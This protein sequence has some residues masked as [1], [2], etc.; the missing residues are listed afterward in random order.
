MKILDIYINGF[1]KFHGRNLSFEDGLN[2]VYVK[3][4]SGKSTI[5]TFIRGMLFGIEKQRGRASRNDL[6]SKFE[7]WENSGTYEGQLRLE[8]KDH[9]YRIERTF[10]KNKKEFKVVDETAGDR[11]DE[12]I[13]RRPLKRFKRDR[14]Q[15]HGQ[16]RSVKKRNR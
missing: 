2:I 8:H 15:Q 11:T 5:H 7:P 13:S 6:Y 3:N 10:Q 16:H 1:V 12:G 9:I 14:I 4:E